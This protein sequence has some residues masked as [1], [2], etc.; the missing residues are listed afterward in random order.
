MKK[1]VVLIGILLFLFSCEMATPNNDD[2][3]SLEISDLPDS[4]IGDVQFPST[5]PSAGTSIGLGI[6]NDYTLFILGDINQKWTDSTG[7]V[8]AAGNINIQ[9]YG[10]ALAQQE[11]INE[12]SLVAGGSITHFDGTV[13]N[14]NVAYGDTYNAQGVSILNGIASQATPIDFQAANT[15]LNNMSLKLEQLPANGIVEDFYGTLIFRGTDE[16]LNVFNISSELLERAHTLDLNIPVES[17]VVINVSGLSTVVQYKGISGNLN[18]QKQKVLFNFPNQIQLTMQ[19][20]G[21]KGSILAPKA[22]LTFNNAHID[23]TIVASSLEGNGESHYF[24][25]IP[26][27]DEEKEFPEGFKVR[28]ILVINGRLNTKV[29]LY[30]FRFDLVD[31]IYIDDI[32]IGE[33]LAHS[34][35]NIQFY[36]DNILPAGNH[37]LDILFTNGDKIPYPSGI[38]GIDI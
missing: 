7:R 9:G 23:G 11:L 37:K 32:D 34:E 30:G 38:N 3:L 28:C 1:I 10:V 15:E 18:S 12:F 35:R 4:S 21:F 16:V 17:T 33:F 20:I 6:A 5:N 2:Q 31:K 26:I 25:F 36:L 29:S 24:P 14:G 19:G 22:N 13:Y 27:I 8:A